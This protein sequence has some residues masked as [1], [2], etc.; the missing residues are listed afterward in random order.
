MDPDPRHPPGSG[1]WKMLR[2]RNTALKSYVTH[3][4]HL[5]FSFLNGGR[6]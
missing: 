5:L 4:K 2:I 1:S 6:G 3:S